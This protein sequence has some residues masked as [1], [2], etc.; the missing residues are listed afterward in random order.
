MSYWRGWNRGVFIPRSADIARRI[1]GVAMFHL[2]QSHARFR[3]DDGSETAATWVA[4]EDTDP[5]TLNV[6]TIYRVRFVIQEGGDGGAAGSEIFRLRYNLNGAG[7]VTVTT[8]SSVIRA[9]A[10]A[11]TSWT[12]SDADATT[13]QIGGSGTFT[14]GEMDEDGDTGTATSFNANEHTE[15]EFVFQI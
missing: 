2:D 7:Y 5:V 15:H 11:D 3:N 9:V 6:D 10:S 12:I 8:T 4:A 14:A 1:V 13:D